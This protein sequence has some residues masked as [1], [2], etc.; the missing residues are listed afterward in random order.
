L[1][2]VSWFAGVGLLVRVFASNGGDVAVGHAGPDGAGL[3]G[4]G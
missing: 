4:V 2:V 1:V 3:R